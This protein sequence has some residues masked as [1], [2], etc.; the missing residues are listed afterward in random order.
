MRMVWPGPGMV[1]T[2]TCKSSCTCRPVHVNPCRVTDTGSLLPLTCRPT[3]LHV[4]N[5][6]L[7]L[8]IALALGFVYKL[9]RGSTPTV[10]CSRRNR[11]HSERVVHAKPYLNR[12]GRRRPG[13]R[14]ER[15]S[16]LQWDKKPGASQLDV[17]ERDEARLRSLCFG[18]F[19]G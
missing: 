13:L 19:L 10:L 4:F 1:L 12:Q 11:K 14:K 9:A 8:S 6:Q 17:F 16:C 3:G 5:T 18:S 2:C 7:Y 15:L